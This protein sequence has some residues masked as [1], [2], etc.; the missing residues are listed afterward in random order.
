MPAEISQE[1]GYVTAGI[2]RNGW[3]APNFGFEQ[4][5]DVYHYCSKQ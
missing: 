5:F 3:V 1:E 4:G 2:G